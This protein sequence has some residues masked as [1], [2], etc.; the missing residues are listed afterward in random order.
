[1]LG[2]PLLREGRRIGRGAYVFG[3][4][5]RAVLTKPTG[6]LVVAGVVFKPGCAVAALPVTARAL[7]DRGRPLADFWG[8]RAGSLVERLA[9]ASGFSE[10]TAI[11]ECE[12]LARLRPM[13]SEVSSGVKRLASDPKTRVS[14][15]AVGGAAIRRLE[16]KFRSQVGASPKRLARIFRLQQALRL[17]A[18][19]EPRTWASLAA[20]AGYS[21]QAHFVREFTAFVGEPPGRF[22]ARERGVSDSFKRGARLPETIPETLRGPL[23]YRAWGSSGLPCAPSSSF[24]GDRP[25]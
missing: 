6:R 20:A 8:R 3:V 11:L 22:L 17:R 19:E 7:G 23:R 10:R 9:A 1:V 4:S 24:F 21:D 25:S 2:D 14:S 12:I 16:R 15:I 5:R 13:D 18:E